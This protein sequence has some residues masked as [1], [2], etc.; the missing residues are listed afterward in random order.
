MGGLHSFMLDQPP[1]AKYCAATLGNFLHL[2]FVRFPI[3]AHSTVKPACIDPF[4]FVVYPP[5][6][7]IMSNFA[8]Q[9]STY[10]PV[11]KN[12]TPRLSAKPSPQPQTPRLPRRTFLAICLA[13]ALV[14][15]LAISASS[16]DLPQTED[17]WREKLTASEFRVLREHGTERPY[18]SSMNSEKRKGTFSCAGCG[19]SLFLS[20]AKFESG[21]GWPSFSSAIRGQIQEKQSFSD[22]F[23]LRK[24]ISCSRC[25]G[26]LGHVFDDGPQPT[27]LR[28]CMNGVALSFTPA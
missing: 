22:R 11:K 4:T 24:E 6:I 27:R 20:S 1:A 5:L 8:F 25:G 14:P 3:T 2:I 9:V 21:T 28:Y 23:L 26:H 13:S 15:T 10:A 16:P 17:G 12:Y 19:E 18:T 7:I